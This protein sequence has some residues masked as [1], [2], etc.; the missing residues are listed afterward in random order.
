MRKSYN[1]ALRDIDKW[2]NQATKEAK[3]KCKSKSSSAP[4]TTAT[5]TP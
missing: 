2:F 3:A 4:T 1:T 5:S